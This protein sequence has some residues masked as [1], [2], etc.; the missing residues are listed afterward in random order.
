MSLP[1]CKDRR[2]CISGL[3][4]HLGIT[5]NF[6]E[7]VDGRQG[8]EQKYEAEIDRVATQRAGRILSDAEYA[9]ALSHIN[10]C[11]RIVKD[12][13]PYTLVFEDDAIPLPPLLD[14]LKGRHWQH[15][16]LIQLWTG[17]TFVSWHGAKRLF[18]NY[19]SYIRVPRMKNPGAVA[20]T[21]SL[22]AARHIVGNAL[23]VD[24]EADWPSCVD[25][26]IQEKQFRCVYPPLVFHQ[27]IEGGVPSIISDH[28]RWAN[29]T[30]RRFL[31]IYTPPL[32]QVL[33]SYRRAP[34]KLLYRRLRK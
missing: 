11:R 33:R 15:A 13:I 18:G 16:D 20:Y 19:V 25:D 2:D 4:N 14:F 24:K 31:G 5:F 17:K 9:C 28:G 8:L 12:E 27:S 30:K 29:K 10:V 1:D 21:I 26:F 22:R 7:A 3:L 23:P 6:H 32:E 34:Y